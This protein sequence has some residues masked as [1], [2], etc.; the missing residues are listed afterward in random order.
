MI[1]I[2][3]AYKE[4]TVTVSVWVSQRQTPPDPKT[5]TQEQVFIWEVKE[6]EYKDETMKWGQP[7]M[8]KVPSLPSL[9]ELNPMRNLRASGQHISKS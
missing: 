9:W 5:K 6:R 1:K 2:K 7:V 8:G 4:I 3:D